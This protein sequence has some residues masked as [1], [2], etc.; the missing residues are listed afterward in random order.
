MDMLALGIYVVLR[1]C[2]N[3]QLDTLSTWFMY[4]VEIFFVI[5]SLYY[6][7]DRLKVFL[8]FPR[9]LIWLPLIALLAGLFIAYGATVIGLPIPFDIAD[10]QGVFL[11]LIIAPVLEE[12]LFRFFLW[13][14]FE[15]RGKSNWGWSL[16]TLLF[17][18]AHWHAVWNVP[19]EWHGFLAYQTLYTLMLGLACGAMMYIYRSI[20]G[21]ILIHFAFNLGFWA[22]LSF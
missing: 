10:S 15:K 19:I 14:P 2:F 9:Q 21:A 17:S 22:T 16:T 12:L 3:S 13:M 4:L 5:W 8:N 6:F 1:F 7:R 20:G 18:Y 11:L